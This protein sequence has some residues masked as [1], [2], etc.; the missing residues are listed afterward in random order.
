MTSPIAK[1]THGFVS[2]TEPALAHWRRIP[3]RSH[4][5]PALRFYPVQVT[6]LAAVYF[7]A[8][9][10][11]LTMA[12]VAEQVT[13]VW[14][15]TGIA[16]AALLS[17][18]YRVWP[19][20]ALGAFLVTASANES[21]GTAAAIAVGN[22]LEALLGAWLLRSLV[23]FD[24][25]LERVNA[26]LG[27]VVLAAGVSTLLSA[28]VGATSLCLGGLQPWTAWPAV[29]SVWWLGDALGDLVVAPLLF[30]WAGW[31]PGAWRPGR[32]F[33][34]GALLL[35]LA[36][37]SLLVFTGPTALFSFQLLA[38]TVFPF[39]IWAA[40]RLGQPAATLTT[41]LA[42]GIA[43][44]GTVRGQ[45]PFAAPTTHVGLIQ[46]QLL[47]GPGR[48]HNPA[49]RRRHD[50]A[51]AGEGGGEATPGGTAAHLG[52]GSC[53]QLALGPLHRRR[54]LVG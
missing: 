34:A 18:G 35:G 38:C 41:F 10:L 19:G 21:F 20:V 24:I 3:G 5:K 42:S 15:P 43:V 45:G 39:A 46:V 30:T 52:G 28:T 13:A 26:V 25:G 47:H 7:A 51:R 16:L 14:P 37:L 12:F 4:K 44:W 8:A 53:G 9:K 32:V 48:R 1:N 36:A 27:L 6:L 11:G 31:R 40:L 29:W 49:P 33:E 50:R 17:L 54:V 22:T 2:A 23:A